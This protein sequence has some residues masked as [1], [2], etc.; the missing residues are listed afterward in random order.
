MWLQVGETQKA[1]G[2]IFKPT[3]ATN[4]VNHEL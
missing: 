1:K 4:V 3:G 2:M